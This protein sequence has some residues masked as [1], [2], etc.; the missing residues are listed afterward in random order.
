MKF[1]SLAALGSI[2][3]SAAFVTPVSTATAAENTPCGKITL[4]EMNWPSAQVITRVSKFFI[5]QGYGCTVQVVPSATVTATK[6]LA[7]VGEPDIVPELWLNGALALNK[8]LD[9]GT[10]VELN[11]VLSDGGIEGWYVPNYIVEKHPEIT[12]IAGLKANPEVVGGVFNQCPEGWACRVS[13]QSLIEALEIKEA[14]FKIFSHGSG[15]TLA[16]S[17]ASAFEEKKPWFGYYWSPTPVL[18]KYP[19][20]RID[21]GPV[22][23]DVHNC[24]ADATCERVGISQFPPSPVAT[25]ATKSFVAREPEVAELMRK[26]AFT[27]A[28]MNEVLAW[29]KDNSASG[30]EAAVYFIQ[31]YKDVWV[32][33]L[34]DDAKKKLANLL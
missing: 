3:L 26:V 11:R 20:T 4:A 14:G 30:D 5:E 34:S 1:V 27:N 21:I 2:A 9:E 7:E 31:N 12:T 19:M 13:S 23:L 25:I 28:Q 32:D 10:V 6:S 29:K 33:W 18:G 8:L 24:N 17:I 22:D 16:T 15:E